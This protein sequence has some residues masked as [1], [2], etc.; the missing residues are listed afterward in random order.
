DKSVILAAQRGRNYAF[1]D[2]MTGFNGPAIVKRFK[3]ERKDDTA[4]PVVAVNV[5]CA[6][7][8]AAADEI[9]LNSIACKLLQVKPT[10]ARI[11]SQQA[12]K[13]YECSEEVAE[14]VQKM[15][16]RMIIGDP[17][18]VKEQ[19]EKIK[20]QYEADELMIITITY[21]I[22]DKLTSYRLISEAFAAD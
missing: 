3:N 2:F 8:Q 13:A 5:S 12:G 6:K 18:Q 15:K 22:E 21:D 9:A 20:D 19:M 14:R 11:T 17:A 7:T 10:D 16:Q 4:Q 1:A